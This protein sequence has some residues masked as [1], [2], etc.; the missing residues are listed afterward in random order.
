M[1]LHEYGMGYVTLEISWTEINNDKKVISSYN[2]ILQ[3][4][5]GCIVDVKEGLTIVHVN[6]CDVYVSRHAFKN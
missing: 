6:I 5:H 1:S 2:P 4:L 3:C